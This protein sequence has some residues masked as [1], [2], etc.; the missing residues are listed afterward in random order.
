MSVD[1]L[2]KDGR[3]YI[4][5][6]RPEKKN[7]MTSAMLDQLMAAYDQAEADDDVRVVVLQGAGEDFST[8][9]DLAE[10]GKEY[11]ETTLDS[12]GRPRRPSQRARLSYDQRYIGRFQ[13]IFN[14][15]KPTLALVK[16]YCLGGGLYLA[17]AS[18]LVIAA[19]TAKIG[20]PEQKLGLSGAAYF[21]AWE[22]MTLGPRK[23]RE[24]LLLA[25]VWNA[26]Q[27]L[28]NGLVNK[29]V[30][31][32]ELEQAGE[33]WAERI[34]RLPRDGIALGKAA[35][36]LAM[37]SLGI[38]RQFAYGPV[39]H[40]LATNVRYEPDEFNFM[41]ERRDSGVRDSNKKREEFY[42]KEK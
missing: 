38:S 2:S 39:L 15:L 25:D 16:G 18:D 41:K 29:V 17:E 31:R 30:P 24:L 33:E 12:K 4:T 22:M 13:R 37:D 3:G 34:V 1:Y 27:A 40:T 6:N 21:A 11:G 23:A 7:A 14:S 42:T 9:H 8:G 35:T 5:I 26:E 10:V 20:H 32:P 36:N 19:D 28:A